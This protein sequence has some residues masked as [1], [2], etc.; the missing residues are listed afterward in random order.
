MDYP[1][2]SVSG[3]GGPVRV[4]SFCSTRAPTAAHAVV[5]HYGRPLE[6]SHLRGTISSARSIV[7]GLPPAGT[8]ES[9][10]RGHK[11]LR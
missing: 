4:P 6:S 9:L 2:D 3:R 1:T 10:R 7:D 5:S 8:C 11:V